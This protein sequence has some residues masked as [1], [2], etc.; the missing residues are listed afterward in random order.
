M[1]PPKK[2]EQASE[3]DESTQQD[4]S[5]GLLESESLPSDETQT[6]EA[7]QP[8][9]A[10]DES[11]DDAGISSL[12]ELAQI[13]ETDVDS[14]LALKAATKI[15]GEEGEVSLRDLIKSHQ[16]Q[17][18]VHRKSA[19]LSEARRKL[20]QEHAER[21][22]AVDKRLEDSGRALEF[23]KEAILGE[24]AGL[25]WDELRQNDPDGYH[26]K[27]VDFQRK[28]ASFN[29]KANE[30][31]ALVQKRQQELAQQH[32]EWVQ[33]EQRALLE[34]VPSWADANVMKKDKEQVRSYLNEVGFPDE[35]INRLSDHRMALVALD[36]MRWRALQSGKKL[37]VKKVQKA[38]KMLK[39]STRSEKVVLGDLNKA[40][41]RLKGS[42]S[43]SDAA[44]ML[45]EKRKQRRAKRGK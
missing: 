38:P 35:D 3:E 42:G 26:T 14:L 29:E 22:S 33:Q 25:N 30:Q 12:T 41:Q 20:D 2:D 5:Q 13:L 39:T 4:D 6:A 1:N 16:L 8:E 37:A 27:W 28:I 10:Q 23:A 36:A 11:G 7:E 21:L 17:G 15:D 43:L 44:A 32:A 34:K 40:R 9:A 31:N 19:E 18:H 45:A 24:F